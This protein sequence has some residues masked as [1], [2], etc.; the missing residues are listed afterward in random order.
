MVTSIVVGLL[1][2]FVANKSTSMKT[3]GCYKEAAW[4]WKRWKRRRRGRGRTNIQSSTGLLLSPLF[5]LR[6]R[7][8]RQDSNNVRHSLNTYVVV[9]VVLL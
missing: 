2:I 3:T 7:N 5:P 1:K 8:F 6:P 4:R 9:I